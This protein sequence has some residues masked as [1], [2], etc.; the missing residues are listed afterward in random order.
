MNGRILHIEGTF[1]RSNLD[2]LVSFVYALNI[3][4][5]KNELWTYLVT[6]RDSVSKPWCLM[7]DF[8][9]TLLPSDKK[10]G[11]KITSSMTRFKNCIDGCNLIE[12]SL[13]GRKIYMVLRIMIQSFWSSITVSKFGTRKMV[14][15]LKMLKE[16][17]RQWSK[18]SV[19]NMNT[20]IEE[21]ELEADSMDRQ[22]ECRVLTADE[23]IRTHTCN[24]TA[25]LLRCKQDQLPLMY[26]RLP[27]SGN[28]GRATLWNHI[29]RN[30]NCQLASWKGMFLSTRGR[31][32]LIKSV[33][34]NL[35]STTYLCSLC[36]LR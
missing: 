27:I 9:E 8:N 20:R 34:S 19:G 12:L 29:L 4:N 1:T 7:G 5:L 31:L 6:F 32:C 13:N 2:C 30:I 17:C 16:R 15:A 36:L 24:F 11:S 35:P 26:L 10:D 28:L 3:R 14:P 25:Q 21:L 23:L 18:A 33:L 22:N